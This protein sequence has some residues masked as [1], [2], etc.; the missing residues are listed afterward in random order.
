MECQLQEFEDELDEV[1]ELIEQD[2]P[3]QRVSLNPLGEL[4][5]R[6][7]GVLDGARKLLFDLGE[8]CPCPCPFPHLP[9]SIRSPL[10]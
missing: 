7:R 2:D 9:L 8:S 4:G 3:E 6:R 5:L 10:P 1:D